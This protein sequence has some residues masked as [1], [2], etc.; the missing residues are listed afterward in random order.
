[1]PRQLRLANRPVRS[2][3][4][5]NGRWLRPGA[6]DGDV[7]AGSVLIIM[8]VGAASALLLATGAAMSLLGDAVWLQSVA[9]ELAL[10]ASDAARG[11]TTGYACELVQSRAAA[12]GVRAT[13]CRMLADQSWVVVEVNRLGVLLGARAHASG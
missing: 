10:L 5:S 13:G 9:D 8:L 4:V 7:G 2:G 6:G 3:W 1:M 12:L 11:L